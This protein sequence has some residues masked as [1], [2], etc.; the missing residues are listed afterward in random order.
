MRP[1]GLQPFVLV[2]GLLMTTVALAC[3][4]CPTS[5]VVW[6]AVLGEG[7]WDHLVMVVVPFLL[8]GA[9]SALLYRIGL[10]PRR[11]A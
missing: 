9:L 1:G 8:I 10:S 4:D 11:E 2:A 6:T 5:R 7:F 3:P